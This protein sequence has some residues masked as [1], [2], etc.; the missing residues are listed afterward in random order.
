MAKDPDTNSA[1]SLYTHTLESLCDEL[2]MG[3]RVLFDGEVG[4]FSFKED[5]SRKIFGWY[6]NNRNKWAGNVQAT[7]IEAMV[8]LLE[9]P[10]PAVKLRVPKQDVVG[11][12]KYTLKGVTI[13]CFGGI[14]YF[15]SA[16]IR[17]TDFVFEFQ[18]PITLLEGNNGC[19]KTS[20]L[21]AIAWCLTGH[22]FRAQRPPELAETSILVECKIGGE[23][24]DANAAISQEICAII[25]VPPK[26]VLI[27]LQNGGLPVDTFVEL[28]LQDQDGNAPVKISRR[29]TRTSRGKLISEAAGFDAL[30]LDP[31]AFDICG[32]MLGLI[33]YI[34]L[35]EVSDLGQAIAK[36]TGIKPLQDLSRHAT[37]VK[38]RLE[39][40][41]VNNRFG[42]IRD[43]DKEYIAE[44][45]SVRKLFSEHGLKPVHDV[46]RP[47]GLD[48]ETELEV[49]FKQFSDMQAGAIEKSDQILGKPKDTAEEK[50]RN[51]LLDEVGPAIGLLDSNRLK[52][53]HSATRL[54]RFA[55]LSEDQIKPIEDLLSTI[56]KQANEI[57]SIEATPDVAARMRL[58]ARVGDWLRDG[59]SADLSVVL[60]D[61]PVCERALG[62][63]IDRVTGKT[64]RSH[65]EQSATAGRDYLGKTLV[66]WEKATTSELKASLPAEFAS[67][68]GRDL[69]DDGPRALV[70]NIFTEEI[71]DSPYFNGG[72][73]PLKA[74]IGLLAEKTVKGLPQFVPPEDFALPESLSRDPEGLRGYGGPRPM[75]H[76]FCPL[77]QGKPRRVQG[78]V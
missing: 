55:S 48:V 76:R 59:K 7:D 29:L 32:R 52:N 70:L 27:G 64:V 75:Y 40:E 45:E 10:L 37:K 22:I 5:D 24:A 77:A 61:C 12:K 13:R 38:Q 50:A 58:Y 46:P 20:F 26:D 51:K 54:R 2:V 16:T 3:R 30:S 71:F 31:I 4:E 63:A 15:H 33:P 34:R 47:D 65:L 66:A 72:L 42:S 57:V 60:D 36:L 18:S 41:S 68:M 14:H 73:S 25:P 74:A 19:G 56:K 78:R 28:V 62:S 35:G 11:A 9:K 53:L 39:G 67:E 1:T 21:N 69:P 17:P 43:C 6:R 44:V 8:D 49:L 23:E